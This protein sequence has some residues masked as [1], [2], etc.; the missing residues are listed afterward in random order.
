MHELYFLVGQKIPEVPP[1]LE[2][3]VHVFPVLASG[4]EVPPILVCGVEVPPVLEV[5]VQVPPVLA[6][7]VE[8]T[9]I[10]AGSKFGHPKTVTRKRKLPNLRVPT[11]LS[12][13]KLFKFSFWPILMMMNKYVY[14]LNQMLN[15]QQ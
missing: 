5:G 11:N 10:L 9:L 3:G 2:I 7:G 14:F 12:K 4:V 1:V 15:I 8:V 13:H 6:D